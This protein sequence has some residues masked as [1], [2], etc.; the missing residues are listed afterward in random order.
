[1]SNSKEEEDQRRKLAEI[2]QQLANVQRQ[3]EEIDGRILEAER[4][5]QSG[6]DQQAYWQTRE[7]DLRA[8]KHDLRV[9]EH[10]L[11]VEKHDLEVRFQ[12][13]RLTADTI[14]ELLKQLGQSVHNRE[15]REI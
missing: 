4:L 3:I 14:A 5:A 6:G 1:M 7:H 15:P 13:H 11:R 9:T 12:G 8:E 10:D 2:E